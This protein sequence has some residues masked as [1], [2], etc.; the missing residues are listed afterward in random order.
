MALRDQGRR[1]PSNDSWIAAAAIS[2]GIPLATQDDD[3][4]G[5]LGLTAIRA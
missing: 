3:Y 5:G 1:M 2:G 4:D